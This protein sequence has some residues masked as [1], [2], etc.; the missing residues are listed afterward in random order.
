MKE[1]KDNELPYDENPESFGKW[2]REAAKIKW[3]NYLKGDEKGIT[4]TE[5][6]AMRN[7][8]KEYGTKEEIEAKLDSFGFNML[9]DEALREEIKVERPDIKLDWYP[10][11]SINE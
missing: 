5:R 2:F 9:A 3:E 7:F 1:Q 4:I 10:R 11:K 6:D 8:L